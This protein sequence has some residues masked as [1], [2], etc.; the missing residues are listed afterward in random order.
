MRRVAIEELEARL[1][2]TGQRLDGAAQP[3]LPFLIGKIRR[4]WRWASSDGL[5]RLVEEDE[6]NPIERGALA[7]RKRRWRA[8][9]DVPPGAARPIFVVGVQR[10]GTNMVMRGLD[11]APEFEVH[12]ENDRRAFF[13]YLLRDD[14]DE[15]IRSSRSRYVLFKPLC[16]SHRIDQLLDRHSSRDAAALWVYRS[17]DG[18]ARSAVAKFGDHDRAVLEAIASNVGDGLW[19]AQR[20]SPATVDVIRSLEPAGLS[21]ETASALFWWARNSLF[22]DLGFAGRKDVL[23]VS[24]DAFVRD[25]AREMRRLCHF[26]GFPY[27]TDLVAHVEGRGTGAGTPPMIDGR[28]RSLCDALLHRFDLLDPPAPATGNGVDRSGE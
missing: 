26:L 28:V 9:H 1:A 12:G 18:R 14:A 24:Y 19:Q 20:L 5:K 4:H 21:P 10:S 13:R 16:D 6:L 15:I 27:R 22:F 25:P 2:R 3:A 11:R 8:R 17:V 23:P 7:L